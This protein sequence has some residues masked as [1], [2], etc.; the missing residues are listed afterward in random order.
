MKIVLDIETIQ[1]TRPEWTKLL[2]IELV[3]ERG[4]SLR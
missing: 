4:F 1:A 2:D 3:S